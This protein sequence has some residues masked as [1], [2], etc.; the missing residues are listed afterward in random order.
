M[1]YDGDWRTKTNYHIRGGG[2]ESQR[3]GEN[4]SD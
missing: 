3:S 1:L 4:N 2:A